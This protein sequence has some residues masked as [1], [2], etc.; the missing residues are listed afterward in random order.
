MGK[1]NRTVLLMLLISSLLVVGCTDFKVPEFDKIHRL[2]VHHIGEKFV[3]LKGSAVFNNPNKASFKVK[4]INVVVNYKDVDVA[5][6]TNTALTKIPAS[7]EFDIPFAI[8]IPTAALRKNLISDLINI[9][10]GK[11]VNLKFNGNLTVSKFGVNR[12]VP[13]DYEKSV[14]VKL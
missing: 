4:N 6:I 8:K 13:I 9:I 14:K 12:E 11:R 2:K 10:G 7:Q 1:H 5:T 3:T